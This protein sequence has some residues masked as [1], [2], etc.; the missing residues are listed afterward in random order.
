MR[1]NGRGPSLSLI[2]AHVMLLP[3]ALCDERP[4]S[5]VDARHQLAFCSL[6]CHTAWSD[7]QQ[8]ESID[9]LIART[10]GYPVACAH[11]GGG[12]EFA[13]ENTMHGFRKSVE[14]GA[15]LL[16]LDLRL[17]R[18]HHL[19]LMHWSSVDD[20]TDGHGEVC[21]HTL[22]Q[23]SELDAA[24]HCGAEFRGK[25]MRIATLR[26]FLDEFVE[27]YP[28]LMFC[29][30]FKDTPTAR[31]TLRFIAPYN[32]SH[33]IILSAVYR[34][35][36]EFLLLNRPSARVPVAT[37]IVETIKL[38]FF[39]YTG[40]LDSYVV[41]HDIYGFVLCRATLPFWSRDLV[42]AVHQLGCRLSVSA[43]GREMTR[44]ERLR[45][46]VEFGVDF[47]MTDAPDQLAHVLRERE[48]I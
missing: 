7:Q 13:P 41:T 29:L 33:R 44:P 18:D 34:E 38:M 31:E 19:V 20:T 36:N 2:D 5:E 15:R 22:A 32:I 40:L 17:T 25:G 48:E 9:T 24:H 6:D 1:L 30:D 3:C 23:L 11:R 12:Y 4:G 16:E 14:C 45:E 43:Y 42:R 28:D 8:V 37:T 39:Y 10:G 35:T 21:D 26:E 27:A 47:I 46:C